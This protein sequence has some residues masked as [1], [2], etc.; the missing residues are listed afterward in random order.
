M[1]DGNKKQALKK[2]FH[3]YAAAITATIVLIVILALL[4]L[5]RHN[6][7]ASITD[8]SKINPLITS[9]QNELVASRD[10]NAIVEVSKN[11][12]NKDTERE[13]KSVG[14]TS[15][16]PGLGTKGGATSGGTNN[17]AG[18]GGNG[19]NSPDVPQPFSAYIA[20]DSIRGSMISKCSLIGL[21]GIC[22]GTYTHTYTLLATITGNNGPGTVS[23]SWSAIPDSGSSVSDSGSLQAGNGT[24][25]N[26]ISTSWSTISCTSYSVTLTLT[27]PAGSQQRMSTSYS[28]SC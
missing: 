20:E 18:S 15:K 3:D 13:G 8:L 28:P 7:L 10:S 26:S 16:S 5:S 14:G 17:G 25:T 23:Y 22:I 24:T 12:K 2:F 4:V 19:S 11:D 21:L 9:E 27:G 6:A 1:V